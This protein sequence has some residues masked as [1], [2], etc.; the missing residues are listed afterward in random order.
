P[1]FVVAS[2][3]V[4]EPPTM[5]RIAPASIVRPKIDAFVSNVTLVGLLLLSI[6]TFCIGN[7]A[8]P[9]FQ[10]TEVGQVPLFESH[11][12]FS[13]TSTTATNGDDDDPLVEPPEPPP[14]TL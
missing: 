5:L 9:S 7:G 8:A 3:T 13:G 6:I 2:V 1:E 10:L 12:T 14:E 4:R 11:M